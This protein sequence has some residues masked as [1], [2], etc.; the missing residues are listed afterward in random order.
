MSGGFLGRALGLGRA[1]LL[2]GFG[3]GTGAAP[4]T[5]GRPCAHLGAPV[6]VLAAAPSTARRSLTAVPLAPLRTLTAIPGPAEAC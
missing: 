1:L 4:T 2:R 6:R 3:G 5:T